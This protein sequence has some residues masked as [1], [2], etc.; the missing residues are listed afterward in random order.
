MSYTIEEFS[1]R[2]QEVYGNINDL[3]SDTILVAGNTM[4]DSIKNRIVN[5]GLNSEGNTI[6]SY[7]T[8]PIYAERDQFIKGGF[9][10][11]GKNNKFGNTIGDRLVPTIRLKQ[12]G[13]K[14]NPVKYKRYSAV[15]PSGDERKTMYLKEGYKELRDV[16]GLRTDIMNF[17]YRGDLMED[18]HTQQV[19]QAVL[20][21]FGNPTQIQKRSSL[22]RR[23]GHVFQPTEQEIEDYKR[24]ANFSISR[25]IR[26]IIANEGIG[27]TATIENVQGFH[28]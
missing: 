18:Y 6:G 17:E 26:G 3:A 12:T 11:Q 2:L 16:Q 7:S 9:N 10:G 8:I 22:E 4:L 25:L 19:A 23:F 20:L 15:K 5:E 14:K 24:N 21:G 13:V 1:D 27:A 28:Y